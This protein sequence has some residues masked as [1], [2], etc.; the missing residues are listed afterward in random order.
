MT[1]TVTYKTRLNPD[2]VSFKTAE[3]DAYERQLKWRGKW[4]GECM[5]F[6]KAGCS[7]M[8]WLHMFGSVSDPRPELEWLEVRD[9]SGNL[10]DKAKATL[11]T[12][13]WRYFMREEA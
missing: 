5:G 8:T 2:P 7:R 12:I 4:H 6:K 1:L 3:Y 9:E 13:G 10:L 11:T